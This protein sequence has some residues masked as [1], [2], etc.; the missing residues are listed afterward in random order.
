M[1]DRRK[2]ATII[3]VT[4]MSI[5]LVGLLVFFGLLAT[6]SDV[7]QGK[8]VRIVKASKYKC[9]YATSLDRPNVEYFLPQFTKG[10]KVAKIRGFANIKVSYAEYIRIHQMIGDG[11]YVAYQGCC[12][13]VRLERW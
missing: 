9:M 5:L 13:S 4:F 2:M 8:L 11:G 1:D 10:L 7:K 3:V 12:Y 6:T